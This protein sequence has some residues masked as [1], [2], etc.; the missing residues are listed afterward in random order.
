MRERDREVGLD[1]LRY[2]LEVE[3]R[4]P[5]SNEGRLVVRGVISV[6]IGLLLLLELSIEEKI[7]LESEEG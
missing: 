4:I 2:R 1:A 6:S 5:V 7:E 3:V